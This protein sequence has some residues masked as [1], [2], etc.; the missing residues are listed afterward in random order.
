MLRFNVVT[1]ADLRMLFDN[2]RQPTSALVICSVFSMLSLNVE[3]SAE[4]SEMF[5]VVLINPSMDFA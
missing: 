3:K 2:S 4:I 5:S 1:A